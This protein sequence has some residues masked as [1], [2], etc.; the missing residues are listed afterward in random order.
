MVVKKVKKPTDPIPIPFPVLRTLVEMYY[1]FQNTR[2]RTSNRTQ[3]NFERN[4]IPLEDMDKY[5]V[6]ELF[7]DAESFEKNIEKLLKADLAN[8]PIYR[9]YLSLIK[10]IGPVISAGL[11]AWI[12]DPG[13]Y[14]TTSKLWQNAGYGMNKFCSE[15]KAWAYDEVEIPK[16]D[17]EGKVTKTKT[18]R[19]N[20]RSQ[21]C[22][23]CGN[24]DHLVVAPQQRVSGLQINWN[25]KFKT[26]GWK[27][28]SS[29]I[30]QKATKAWYRAIYDKE[31]AKLDAKY[32]ASG[33]IDVRGV[34]KLQHNP[35]HHFEA[36]KRHTVKQ[37]LNH[38]WMVWRTMEGQDIR[39]PYLAGKGKPIHKFI[40]PIVDDG[41][42]P[43]IVVDKLNELNKRTGIYPTDLKPD[44]PRKDKTKVAEA[45]LQELNED[46]ENESD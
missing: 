19:L 12:G 16:T 44:I 9:D 46:D 2:I 5:G 43:K 24:G 21:I 6:T 41:E 36:A 39:E 30:K 15:C 3:M 45:E 37:F 18:K 26:L 34:K 38:L 27:I 11:I 25:P 35:K 17:R 29:F 13:K 31:R 23:K 42:L 20:G 14:A 32:P 1:D 33:K 8:R 7:K 22:N 28:G 10:G 4:V 40:P